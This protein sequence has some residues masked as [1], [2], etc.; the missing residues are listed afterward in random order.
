MPSAVFAQTCDGVEIGG[1]CIGTFTPFE[2][3]AKYGLISMLARIFNYLFTIL[4][5]VWVIGALITVFDYFRSQGKPELMSR[6]SESISNLFKGIS[7]GFFTFIAISVVGIIFG[8]GSPLDWPDQFS[9]CGEDRKM[10]LN[11]KEEYI[12]AAQKAG[13]SSGNTIEIYCCRPDYVGWY[14]EPGQALPQNSDDICDVLGR[15]TIP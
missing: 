11:V 14:W 2:G 5:I 1:L 4:G 12:E 10:Y 3:L 8:A 13:F 9:Q 6:G 15:E 7:I